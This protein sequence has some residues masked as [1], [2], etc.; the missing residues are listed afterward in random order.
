MSVKFEH[1][2]SSMIAD[3]KNGTY[4]KQV[5]DLHDKELSQRHI[6]ELAEALENNFQVAKNITEID[7]SFNE[8]TELP[9]DMFKDC[10]GL[11]R[12]N[13]ENNH[14]K[15]LPRLPDRPYALQEFLASYNPLQRIDLH[16]FVNC[17]SLKTVYLND[18]HLTH[19]PNFA[20]SLSLAALHL[21]NNPLKDFPDKYFRYFQHLDIIFL[22]NTALT[23]L[24]NLSHCTRLQEVWVDDIKIPVK[25]VLPTI[26]V[27]IYESRN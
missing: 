27:M 21:N 10:D 22:N 17:I 26:H 2:F 3:L 18:T 25:H 23:E 20:D 8:I 14:L 1:N 4:A 6:Q 5:I 16:Y 7:L 15:K 24:P 9:S 13:L 12:L 11:R 19:A